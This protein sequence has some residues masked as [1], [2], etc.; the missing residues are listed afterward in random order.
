MKNLN[1]L[2]IEIEKLISIKG[3]KSE[4]QLVRM[5]ISKIH[6]IC[7]SNNI[8]ELDVLCYFCLKDKDKSECDKP[9]KGRNS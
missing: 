2:K 1:E 6:D 4:K 8:N 3:I 9:C 5:S 7:I